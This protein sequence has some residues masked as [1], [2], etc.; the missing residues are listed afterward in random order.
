MKH[1]TAIDFKPCAWPLLIVALLA[2]GGCGVTR[3]GLPPRILIDGK[4]EM[5]TVLELAWNPMDPGAISWQ[6]LSLNIHAWGSTGN[7]DAVGISISHNNLF[8]IPNV[9][10]AHWG[11]VDSDGRRFLG[12]AHVDLYGGL[13]RMIGASNP[14]V[15]MTVGATHE[16]GVQA[17]ALSVG[18][19]L[20]LPTTVLPSVRFVGQSAHGRLEVGMYPGRARH[21]LN[22]DKS[23][24]LRP[25]HCEDLIWQRHEIALIDS[26]VSPQAP[27]TLS[28]DPTAAC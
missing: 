27:R 5:Y 19:G 3:Y 24:Y 7:G 28:A 25:E 20:F 10:Y 26:T 23:R 15:E 8:M 13:F 22:W 9:S 11:P 6:D 14:I 18:A 16:D 21:M 1:F 4:D 2:T 12:T 17:Q